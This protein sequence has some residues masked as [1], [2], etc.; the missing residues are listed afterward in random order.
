MEPDTFR[1]VARSS[2]WLWTSVELTRRLVPTSPQ[3]GDVHVFI[4]RPG[5]MRVEED[6]EMP[7]LVDSTG[8]SSAYR[9][10]L[11][12]SGLDA[13]LPVPPVSAALP[14]PQDPDAPSP[15]LRP[16]GLVAERPPPPR[17]D[18]FDDPMHENYRWIAM[19][20]P[21]ELADGATKDGGQ[22]PDVAPIEFLE[23]V[24]ID[25]EGRETLDAVVRPTGAYD[26][27]CACCPLLYCALTDEYENRPV[28]EPHYYASAYR[29]RLDRATGICVSV[30]ELGGPRDGAGFDVTIYDV[31]V[32]YADTLFA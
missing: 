9:S 5:R 18:Y 2:P 32:T 7:R 8:D 12:V 6:G 11:A 1:A 19:L 3:W 14:F 21:R 28:R 30:S 17:D 22:H 10:A 15:M 31:D 27:R 13:V 4:R 25:R 24:T 26:P 16:D 29:V 20:D 23:L